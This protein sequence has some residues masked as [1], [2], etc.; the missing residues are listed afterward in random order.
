[1]F[2]ILA[3]KAR[4][5]SLPPPEAIRTMFP[6]VNERMR[7]RRCFAD[8][9]LE[10]AM[11]DRERL[12]EE[13]HLRNAHFQ[14]SGIPIN[15]SMIETQRAFTNI[16]P[17]EFLMRFFPS[18]NPHVLELVFQ[19]CGGNIEKCIVQLMNQGNCGKLNNNDNNDKK[20]MMHEEVRNDVQQQTPAMQGKGSSVHPAFCT[21]LAVPHNPMSNTGTG[22]LST[23][24]KESL[25]PHSKHGS[26]VNNGS[27]PVGKHLRE[28]AR[29]TTQTDTLMLA[30]N[31]LL[32]QRSAFHTG[33]SESLSRDPQGLATRC[34]SG[35]PCRTQ[36]DHG[37]NTLINKTDK[38][39]D[40]VLKFSVEALIGK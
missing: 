30:E 28:N 21:R 9:D 16:S 23:P 27:S 20:A 34:E 6:Y 40:T 19:G 37:T 15:A 26:L 8:K 24:A 29:N 7:K 35:V 22:S 10:A 31:D 12:I 1:M 14:T 18:I 38:K 32:T 39:T 2:S 33:Q 3:C 36:A 25:P 5:H 11:F 13:C 4:L 17:K